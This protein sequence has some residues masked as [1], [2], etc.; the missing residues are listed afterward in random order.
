MLNIE[1]DS[2]YFKFRQMPQLLRKLLQA[3]KSQGLVQ[4]PQNQSHGHLVQEQLQYLQL[5]GPQ[6]KNGE[7]KGLIFSDYVTEF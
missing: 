2:F 5:R 4:Q 7:N 6:L 1:L 3:T